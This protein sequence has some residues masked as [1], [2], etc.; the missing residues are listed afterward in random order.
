MS[1][2]ETTQTICHFQANY[3]RCNEK[4]MCN[5]MQLRL[6]YTP[7]CT[8]VSC[9]ISWLLYWQQLYSWPLHSY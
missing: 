3:S 6:F 1:T 2:T 9:H 8:A 5:A 4:L 7:F